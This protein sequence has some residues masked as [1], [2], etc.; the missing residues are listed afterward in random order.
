MGVGMVATS[1]M[2]AICNVLLAIYMLVDRSRLRR[3]LDEADGT[4]A[5]LRNQTSQ[6]QTQLRE[7]DEYID[8]IKELLS[9]DGEQKQSRPVDVVQTLPLQEQ[10]VFSPNADFEHDPNDEIIYFAERRKTPKEI[11]EL[12]GRS[13]DEVEMILSLHRSKGKSGE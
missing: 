10:E 1:A 12:T 8:Q 2:I 11:A 4:V 5:E 13:V 7:T 6:L 9:V 3:K